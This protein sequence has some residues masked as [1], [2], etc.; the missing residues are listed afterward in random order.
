MS[1]QEQPVRSGPPTD[2]GHFI[3]LE[4]GE[5]AGKSTQAGLLAD[6]LR[7]RG[8]DVV[9][10]REP[11][12]TPMGERIRGLLLDPGTA[13]GPHAEA[14]L[15]A[16]DRGE[17]VAG[18]VRPALERGAIVITDRYIDSSI[19]YQGYGRGLDPETVSRV[20]RWAT[21]EL[22]PNLTVLLDLPVVAGRE[23]LLARGGTDRLESEAD[24]FHERVRCGFRRLASADPPRYAVVDATGDVQPVAG[25][26]R[27]AVERLLP[28]A[29]RATT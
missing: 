16:A 23:R 20:S 2:I 13:L 3:S 28:T 18:I 21:G 6:W 29:M 22:L 7:E 26:V 27:A 11:G 19:A 15:Y 17:H 9:L 1:A 12:A 24:S 5:G 25:Q 8:H 4:G 10:T 14:L